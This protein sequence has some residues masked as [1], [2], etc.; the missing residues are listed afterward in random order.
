MGGKL[1]IQDRLLP[2]QS[3]SL[4]RFITDVKSPQRDFH[5]PFPD[6]EVDST[7]QTQ[8]GIFELATQSQSNAIGGQFTELLNIYK[9][10]S[11][12]RNTQVNAVAS[13]AYELIQ[14]NLR[15]K[16]ACQLPTT[17]KWIEGAIE[18]GSSIY[19][20]VGYRTF[21]DP[22]AVEQ[23]GKATS[24][25]TEASLPVSIIAEANLPLV[26]LGGVLDP[27]ISNT[28][29]EMRAVARKF[30][31]DGEMVYA[32]QYCKINFKW[33]SS[34]NIEKSALGPTKWKI[35][36]GVRTMEELDEEDIVE[37]EL[38]EDFDDDE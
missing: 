38:N 4:A 13:V 25:G 1:F 17:R 31:S 14:W 9:G 23:T 18:E 32:V 29:H 20:I 11:N 21:I 10:K 16:E 34:K 3:V 35:H 27:G 12:T 8:H 19:F 36:W 26:S 28:K 30:H 33:Y 6:T 22:S 2:I 5:D 7:T 24:T 15:F 37:A